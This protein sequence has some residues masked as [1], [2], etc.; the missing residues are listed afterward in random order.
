MGIHAVNALCPDFEKNW[1]DFVFSNLRH[2]EALDDLYQEQFESNNARR[3]L[4][5]ESPKGVNRN[6]E[7]V[8][9]TPEPQIVVPPPIAPE[10][11]ERVQ[12][13][14]NGPVP[15]LASTTVDSL[16]EDPLKPDVLSVESQSP[17]LVPLKLSDAKEQC[18]AHHK[19]KKKNDRQRDVVEPVIDFM[20][21]YYKDPDVLNLTPAN[22]KE[23]VKL[24]PLIPNRNSVPAPQRNSF[25][26][27]YCYGQE[28]VVVEGKTIKRLETLVRLTKS[29]IDGGHLVGIRSVFNYLKDECDWPYKVPKLSVDCDELLSPLPR[30]AF[31]EKEILKIITMPLFTGC[32]SKERIWQPGKYFVQNGLYW[33]YLIAMMA[34]MRQ[35]E[36]VKL[37]CSDIV[38]RNSVWYFD[39]RPF[40]PTNGRVKIKDLK[41]FKASGSARV[42][43]IHPLL[44]KLGLLDRK[45]ELEKLGCKRLFPDLH[46]FIRKNGDIRWGHPLSKSYQYLKRL[47]NFDR[48]DV[49]LYSLRHSYA[50]ALDDLALAD[51][52]RNRM[53]GHQMHGTEMGYGRKNR[54]SDL[55]VELLNELH[56]GLTAQ[57]A[58]PLLAA[59]RQSR[60]W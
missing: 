27:R 18:L 42:V 43:P 10:I 37:D 6:V 38:E 30:D 3:T 55:Q 15:T 9:T 14:T 48:D 5:S 47:L 59:K 31:D 49:C 46:P 22:I 28:D 1:K 35:G 50:D 45:E 39:L 12:E 57:V 36:I 32:S 17:S 21:W 20:I 56:T 53:M 44:I 25:M 24:L 41:K 19:K 16:V 4:H 26:G 54:L 2:R 23:F 29:T 7:V 52:M 13:I 33:G 58:E 8:S 60:I 11:N 40:D 51:R 34:G